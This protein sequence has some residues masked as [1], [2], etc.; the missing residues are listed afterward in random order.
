MLFA[1]VSGSQPISAA[2][3]G[4]PGYDPYAGYAYYGYGYADPYGTYASAYQVP[5]V[6][7]PSLL[8]TDDK[9]PEDERCAN[10]T[11]T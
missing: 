4:Y 7:P 11:A 10:F 3:G 2:Y 8:P 1:G 6:G 5:P 9:Q